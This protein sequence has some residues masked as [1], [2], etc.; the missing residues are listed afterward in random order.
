MVP[1]GNSAGALLVTD[2]IPQLSDAGGVVSETTAPHKPGS[3][4]TVILAGVALAALI[5]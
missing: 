2:K 1:T 3:L 4:L 5:L